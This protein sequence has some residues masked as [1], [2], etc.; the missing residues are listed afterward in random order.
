MTCSV[1][2]GGSVWP[3]AELLPND[4]AGVLQGVSA[5]GDTLDREGR[6]GQGEERQ[7]REAAARSAAASAGPSFVRGVDVITSLPE[8]R[9]AYPQLQISSV[10]G[11]AAHPDG[12]RL[13]A[14]IQPVADLTTTA[15][16]AMY[17]PIDPSA[18]V[19]SW[20][21]W[22]D[23]IWIGPRHTYPNGSICSFETHDRTWVRG[24][25]PQPLF[26]LHALWVVRQ[27][28][29]RAY[30]R[31]PGQQ[32]IHT[33]IGRLL[34]QRPDE[35]CGCGSTKRYGNCHIADD[36]NTVSAAD[37]ERFRT[38]DFLNRRAIPL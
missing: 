23:G 37:V 10:S 34:E 17:W 8:A 6:R 22:A 3:A 2:E 27:M 14:V 18:D 15:T 9:L 1:Y 24:K 4:L 20:S 26:D 31:W 32:R 19:M 16:I 13:I 36:T 38:S 35:L 12:F 30:G 25:G 11:N 28:Y 33:P 21:W 7:T 5:N 29:L